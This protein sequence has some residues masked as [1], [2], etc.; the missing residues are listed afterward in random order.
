MDEVVATGDRRLHDPAEQPQPPPVL[1][2]DPQVFPVFGDAGGGDPAPRG[3][4]VEQA[5]VAGDDALGITGVIERAFDQ[6]RAG[7]EEVDEVEPRQAERLGV[8]LIYILIIRPWLKTLPAL[9]PR[10]AAEAGFFEKTQ[11]RLTGWKTKIAA[12]LTLIGGVLVGMYDHL[13]PYVTG[14]NWAPITAKLPD[15]SL[16]VGMMFIALL[17]DWLRSATANPPTVITQ[18]LDD[19]APAVVVGVAG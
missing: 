2:A 8:L 14:Q 1:L 10:F 15:W 3:L 13:I 19:G 9:A 17:F 11:A 4:G 5:P 12:R 7:G 18:K 16:P 6:E